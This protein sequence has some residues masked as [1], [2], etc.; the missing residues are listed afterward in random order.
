MWALPRGAGVEEEAEAAAR[1]LWH[2]SGLRR[3]RGRQAAAPQVESDSELT[4]LGFER[5]IH[6][7][8][9]S[10]SRSGCVFT[11]RPARVPAPPSPSPRRR[12]PSPC[13]AVAP[14]TARSSRCF[15]PCLWEVPAPSVCCHS[16]GSSA[17]AAAPGSH[18]QPRG[19]GGSRSS[20]AASDGSPDPGDPP[21]PTPA[22]SLPRVPCH[23]RDLLGGDGDTWDPGAGDAGRPGGMWPW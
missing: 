4:K 23:T 12:S 11:P 1:L 10:V 21:A 16:R 8:T 9:V 14:G 6:P 15:L 13:C 22:S 7:Q 18:F 5:E 20:G 2:R 17:P 19:A 3:L